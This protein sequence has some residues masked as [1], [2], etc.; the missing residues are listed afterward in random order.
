MQQQPTTHADSTVNFQLLAVRENHNIEQGTSQQAALLSEGG[1]L[2]LGICSDVLQ[3]YKI[4]ITAIT[5]TYWC[6]HHQA[7]SYLCMQT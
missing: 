7:S 4:F 3:G 5:A 2:L 6:Y 1:E